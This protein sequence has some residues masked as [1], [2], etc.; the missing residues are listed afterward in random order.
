MKWKTI[1][2]LSL[3][4]ILMGFISVFGIIQ[5][6]EWLLWL[7]IAFVSAFVLNKQTKKLLVTHAAI[8]GLF[9]GILYA[10]I[11][12]SLFEM[13]LANNLESEGFKQCDIPIEP[14]YFFLM[15]GPFLGFVYGLIVGLIALIIKK[16]SKKQK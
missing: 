11:L 3:F 6:I 14:Q 13:Y 7:I 9:M 16:I 15:A 8:T 10:I 4:A 1:L 12:S 2:L 5:N